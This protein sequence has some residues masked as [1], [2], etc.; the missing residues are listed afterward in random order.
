[1][2]RIMIQAG[3]RAAYFASIFAGCVLIGARPGNGSI[4]T[5]LGIGNSAISGY[6]GTGTAFGTVTVTWTGSTTADISFHALS[7]TTYAYLFGAANAVG[8]NVNGTA[9]VSNISTSLYGNA[10]GNIV[11]VASGNED[12][13]G[14]FSISL[15]DD[16]ASNPFSDISFTLTNTSGTWTS[17]ADVLTNNNKGYFAAAH[18]LVYN[19]PIVI[20]NGAVV[21]GYAADGTS[22]TTNGPPPPPVPEPMS[23]AIWGLGLGICS[24]VGMRRRI[25]K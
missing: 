5:D 2:K 18:V 1:V 17:D 3:L 11:N 12:G 20:Q 24:V 7:N 9:T 16:N 25:L 19:A 15:D 10:G 21:T 23:L 8:V 13:F 14:N 6:A 4:T 22:G